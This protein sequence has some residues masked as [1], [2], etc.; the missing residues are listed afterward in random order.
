MNC[1]VAFEKQIT[2]L[3]KLA[4]R[5]LM[6]TTKTSDKFN[7]QSCH[8]QFPV[9]ALVA[10]SG[11]LPGWTLFRVQESWLRVSQD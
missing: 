6:L 10:K 9:E 1:P 3:F 5:F 7:I 8:R 11:D 2:L 4:N